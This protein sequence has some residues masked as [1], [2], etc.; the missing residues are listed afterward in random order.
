MTDDP[1]EQMRLLHA[2]LEEEGDD[3]LAQLHD[4]LDQAERTV[5]AAKQRKVRDAIKR[6]D[7]S[8]AGARGP[9]S[10]FAAR[11]KK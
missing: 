2:F 10:I 6:A 4:E 11:E 5:R 3:P 7:P 8:K 9:L 1:V